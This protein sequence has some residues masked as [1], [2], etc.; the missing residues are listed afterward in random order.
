MSKKDIAFP[1]FEGLGLTPQQQLFV[2]V[3][4]RPDIG[5]NGTRAY[6]EAYALDEIED[7]LTAQA[8]ASRLLRNVKVQS[9]I[10]IEMGRLVNDHDRLASAVLQSWATTAFADALGVLEVSGPFVTLKSIDE[11]PPH[12]RANV[13][14]IEN[15]A[16]GIKVMLCS[17]DKARE[18]IA[19]A[20][21]LFAEDNKQVGE[22]YESLV[23]RLA[24]QEKEAESHE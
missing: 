7:V 5:F 4:C 16:N 23:A 2:V 3:Y 24:R 14:S 12:L 6:I 1:Q 22:G 17:K 8:A 10:T 13:Q 15:T 21:G 11:I 18:N 20:L 9:A 19:K